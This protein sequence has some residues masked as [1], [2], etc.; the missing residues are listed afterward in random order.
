MNGPESIST[1]HA[2][3]WP[4]GA[5]AVLG[6]F[7]LALAPTVRS[8]AGEL[9]DDQQPPALLTAQDVRSVVQEMKLGFKELRREGLGA[10]DLFLEVKLASGPAWLI[11]NS[12]SCSLTRAFAEQHATLEQINAW[13]REQRFARAYVLEKSQTPAITYEIQLQ[14]FVPKATIEEFIRVFDQI[15]PKFLGFLRGDAGEADDA[16]EPEAR[17]ETARSL[18]I[19]G[20]RQVRVFP[21][22]PPPYEGDP[23]LQPVGPGAQPPIEGVKVTAVSPNSPAARAGLRPGDVI[24]LTEGEDRVPDIATLE[25][26]IAAASG[27]LHLWALDRGVYEDGKEVILR[28]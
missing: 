23:R 1:R 9:P 18:G 11:L 7:L 20:A 15:V 17:H 19:V 21:E 28:W 25:A 5:L 27:Y 3:A 13:N 4:I 12:G 16:P 22:P 10:T 2:P 6:F 8:P 14:P 26:R 24:Y